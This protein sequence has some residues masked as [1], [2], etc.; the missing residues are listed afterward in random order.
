MQI[1][2]S[3]V[4]TWGIIASDKVK[5][6]EPFEGKKGVIVFDCNFSDATGHVDLFNG[7]SVEG[8]DYSDSSQL[9]SL[10]LYEIN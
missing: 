7:S 4:F 6:K 2:A 10:G 3:F 1:V 5:K 8:K 9:V